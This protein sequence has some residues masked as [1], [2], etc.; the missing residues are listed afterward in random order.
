MRNCLQ[1]PSVCCITTLAV[2]S[3]SPLISFLSAQET[4]K[5]VDPRRSDGS[6]AAVVVPDVPLVHTAQFLP[7][8]ARGQIEGKDRLDVQIESVL[9]SLD[10]SLIAE[11]ASFAQV[12]KI[13]VVAVDVT[14]ANKVRDAL[15]LKFFQSREAKP[16]VSYVTGKLWYPDALVEMDA[17]VMS[18][19]T[20]AA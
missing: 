9:N 16:A 11:G 14:V 8:D 1:L 2:L 17:V 19:A 20:V 7:V 4:A 3:M 12:V 6:S 5:Y 15:S 13:N 18:S 10:I